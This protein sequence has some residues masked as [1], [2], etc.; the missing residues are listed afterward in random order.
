MLSLRLAR[1][2]PGEFAENFTR[3]GQ[4][5]VEMEPSSH[6]LV[7]L[8][9]VGA[10]W[11]S[12]TTTRPVRRDRPGRSALLPLM[13]WIIAVT[14]ATFRI[15]AG[16]ALTRTTIDLSQGAIWVGRMGTGAGWAIVGL[17][18]SW[19]L[20]RKNGWRGTTPRRRTGRGVW[21]AG[22][23]I[24]ASQFL[25]A[26]AGAKPSV[27][28]GLAILAASLT[29]VYLLPHGDTDWLVRHVRSVFLALTYA[30]LLI[31]AFAPT[32]AFTIP[33]RLPFPGG[34]EMRFTGI[35]E[36]PNMLG[37]VAAMA[38]VLVLWNPRS[39]WTFIHALAALAT[40]WLAESWT[41]L[42]ALIPA[43]TALWVFRV[44]AAGGRRTI[45]LVA[46]AASL[47]LLLLLSPIS[48][49]SEASFEDTFPTLTARARVWD[50]AMEHWRASPVFGYGPTLFD[51]SFRR[52][53]PHLAWVGQAHNQFFQSI[54]ETGILGLAA[55]AFYVL[56]LLLYAARS[57]ARTRGLSVAVVTLFMARMVTETPLRSYG[58][59]F[60]LLLHLVVFSVLL[61]SHRTFPSAKGYPTIALGGAAH[62]M[63]FSRA[64]TGREPNE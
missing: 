47:S 44:P 55:F 33:R 58:F 22:M 45:A 2:N 7:V 32:W 25:A 14:G 37:A 53:F 11:G 63:T 39:R 42:L 56:M 26:V 34:L 62:G 35:T 49:T 15:V 38:L 1:R 8:P 46:C 27:H 12:Q 54:S 13:L 23:A 24:A 40:L 10:V 41:S 59:G 31:Y 36:H 52:S 64:D 3:L 28:L 57:A 9:V 4:P 30:S 29:V 6:F 48:Y 17:A 19:S 5:V 16:D 18:L 51:E 20:S 50:I 21:L 60:N 43:V 61:V